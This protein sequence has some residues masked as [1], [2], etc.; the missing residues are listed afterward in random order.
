VDSSARF[1]PHRQT[2]QFSSLIL[3]YLDGHPSVAPFYE[4][5]LDLDGFRSAMEARKAFPTNRSLIVDA[6]HRAYKGSPLSVRQ[7]ENLDLLL[8]E[9]TFTIC[10]AHQPNIFSG[11]LY[12]VYKTLHAITLADALAR[13]IPEANFVPVFYIGSEDNDLDELSQVN[14]DGRKIRWETKQTGAVGRMKVD[15]NLIALLKQIE[16]R[17]G[18]EPHGKELMDILRDAYREGDTIAN[19]TFRLLNALFSSYGLLVLQ[20]DDADLKRTMIPVFRNDLLE[21]LPHALVETSSKALSEHYK[22]QVTPREINLFYLEE[23]GRHRITRDQGRFHL[24]GTSKSFTQE[25]ILAELDHH[26]ERFSPNVVLRGLYQETIL[27]DIA[28]VGGGSEI[29]Y[30]LEL[31]PL[32]QQFQVPFP[33]LMLR[34]SFLLIDPVNARRLNQSGWSAE[35]LFESEYDLMN[36]LVKR[37]SGAALSLAEEVRNLET[38][39]E[40]LKQKAARIDNTLITHVSALQKKAVDRVSGLEAKMLRAEKRK[41]EAE[42]RQLQQARLGLFPNN[43]LQERVDN[44]MPWYARFGREFI[45][46]VHRHSPSLAPAFVILEIKEE[47]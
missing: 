40:G 9:N 16:G 39:Y 14:L 12:F 5:S 38:Y 34:N 19:A 22:S 41:F 35:D 18:V 23:G 7:Q 2:K 10:T 17:V 21:H 6:F 47:A 20:P 46:A 29:A 8:R 4:H 25:E 11:Y 28:F 45:S 33:V 32:F 27:P 13:E 37:Q 30:W 44:F 1:I 31:K 42:Q 43:G 15:K 3:D 36:R 26:P 24:D